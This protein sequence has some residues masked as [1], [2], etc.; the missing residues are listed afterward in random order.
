MSPSCLDLKARIES[1][2]EDYRLKN[3]LLEQNE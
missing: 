1:Q 3:A 2:K